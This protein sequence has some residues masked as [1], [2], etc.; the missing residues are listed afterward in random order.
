M[1]SLAPFDLTLDQHQAATELE[2]DV[3]LTAGAGTGKTRTL[4]ARY[5]HL[6]A[7]GLNE[8]Q[9]VAVTFTEKAA[10]E[11]RNR[12]RG[13]VSDLAVAAEG[14]ERLRWLEIESRMDAAR[15]GTMHS[16]CAEVLRSHP[17]EARIDPGFV[18]VDE[19]LGLTFKAQAVAEALAWAAGDPEAVQLFRAFST[20]QLA[21]VLSRLLQSRL[22]TAELL[23]GDSAENL[24]R[25]L[26]AAVESFVRLGRVV[27]GIEMLRKLA[28]GGEM[29]VDAGPSLAP[30]AA[31]LLKL[32]VELEVTLNAGDLMGTCGVLFT[33]R[34][35][36]LQK[37]G[38]SAKSR[39]RAVIHTL[40]DLYDEHL[41][42]WIGGANAKDS[43]P[44]PE[45]DAIW[46][47]QLQRL[48][49]LFDR[50]L[51]AYRRALDAHLALDFDDLEAGALALL[52]TADVGDRWRG[53]LEAVLVDEF[54]DTNQ[55]QRRIIDALVG[56]RSGCLFA[57]G[58]ARQSIYRFRGADVRVFRRKRQEVQAGGGL[59]TEIELNF[60]AHA[61][62]LSALDDVVGPLMGRE[63][64]VALYQ[65]PYTTLTADRAE[66]SGSGAGPHL[67]IVL[68]TGQGAEQGRAAAARALADRL[69]ELQGSGVI[70]DWGE[71]ALLFRA[72][73]G[74]EA[75]ESALEAAG[76]PFVTVA[77]RGFYD[78]PE[79]RDLVNTLR[80]IADPS[81]D[82][83]LAGFLRS[84]AVGLSDPG[85]YR[86]RVSGGET[87]PLQA[88]LAKA[89]QLLE[90]H[91]L[92]PARRAQATLDE[93]HPLAERLPVAE[94]ISRLVGRLDW[95]AVLASSHA[96]LWRNL[97]KL[98][99]DAQASALV[100]VG[101]FLEYLSV[102]REAGAREGEAPAGEGGALQ[103]MTIHKAKGLEFGLVV[104]ADASRSSPRRA[105]PVYL[106]EEVG[107]A[108]AMDLLV[109]EPTAYRLA[110]ALDAEQSQAEEDRLLY[111]AATRARERLIVSG[112]LSQTRG[113]WSTAG[114]MERILE[115]MDMDP[116]ALAE[117]VGQEVLVKLPGGQL[118][119]AWTAPDSERRRWA[120]AGSFTAWPDSSEPPLY[121]VVS[122]PPKEEI[123]LDLDE[124][125]ERT[126]R[127]T[128]SGRRA[129]AAAVGRIV[130][131]AIQRSAMPGSAGYDR[132]MENEAFRAGL[133]DPR[134]RQVA[135]AESTEML[136]RLAAHALWEEIRAAQGAQ[137]EVPFTA[138][139]PAGQ[140][141]S[142]Q[143]D[144]LWRAERGWKIVDFKTDKLQGEAD[145]AAAVERHRKQ[146]ER[147]VRS[148]A[149]ILGVAPQ[150]MLCFLD[151]DGEVHLVEV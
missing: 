11:M 62:L 65:V 15:I 118:L 94:L 34:R 16:L 149:S 86:L 101:A 2:R 108:A 136:G 109:G 102:L 95:R 89:E 127:A 78:R 83:A 5:V 42:T 50:A 135:V 28:D 93:L 33:I 9:I 76:I 77:G 125:P 6:L 106:M 123:D 17:A 18:V 72:S 104:L 81:D 48:K 37:V 46:A 3:L 99:D 139:D 79:I 56:D 44:A 121:R 68:G 43:P 41:N 40:Q 60:R 69:V 57:V 144:L 113:A 30:R 67:E 59:A 140:V 14:E 88:A 35:E 128:G 49:T 151:A 138:F 29:E 20:R 92:A 98:V 39:A 143:I 25:T 26:L 71:V 23:G 61:P 134:Q 142:G 110:R 85:L 131:A 147:Y 117:G 1:D 145:L 133:V 82:L 66:P 70:R 52:E 8:R 141:Q 38:G 137:R 111:V 97:D 10:R 107:A 112:H 150:G 90:P 13:S 75:Y 132:F 22:E 19:G 51:F 103:L 105:Q 27:G 130:H 114:W 21:A 58:D 146:V 7:R 32:W 115:L 55:R 148:A 45:T 64:S 74:F 91:D 80:A 119:R 24:N 47:E 54:Q 116:K 96:R 87:L 124:E 129:P 126:W 73:A 84:P 120:Q 100:N 53:R 31:R 12:I 63:D 36:A 4:V 122:I